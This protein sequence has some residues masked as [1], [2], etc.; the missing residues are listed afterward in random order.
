MICYPPG[1]K[2]YYISKV[3]CDSPSNL[4]LFMGACRQRLGYGS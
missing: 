1:W 2:Y 3:R 4:T